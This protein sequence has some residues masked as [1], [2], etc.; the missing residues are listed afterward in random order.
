MINLLPTDAKR[1]IQA[2]RMN[3]VLLR[4]NILTIAAMGMLVGLCFLFYVILHANQSTAVTTNNDNVT[5]AASY[6]TVRTEADSYKSNLSIANKILDNSVNYTTVI[7]AITQLLPSGVI[8]D[9][10]NLSATDFG[11]QT[12]FTAHAKNF[13]KATELK[14][15]FQSSS[16]FTNVFFQTLTDGSAAPGSTELGDYPIAVTISGKLSKA[17]N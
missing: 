5:K 6:A 13:T 9:A 17:A 16:L 4:Y 7:F 3:V 15:K 1:D 8:L 2:A 11:Q 10:L 12:S 14:D